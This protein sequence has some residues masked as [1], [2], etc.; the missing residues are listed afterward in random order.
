MTKIIIDFTLE[1]ETKGTYRYSEDDSRMPK[2]GTL[3]IKK[4]AFEAGAPKK[5]KVTLEHD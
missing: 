3:Y 2:I 5:V 4:Y 1:R